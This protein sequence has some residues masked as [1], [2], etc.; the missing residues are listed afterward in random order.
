MVQ[1]HWLES[2]R[3]SGCGEVQESHGDCERSEVPAAPQL[4]PLHQT[5]RCHGPGPCKAECKYHEQSEYLGEKPPGIHVSN[6][7]IATL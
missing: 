2:H 4:V 3:F 5:E 1:G 6:I 7:P